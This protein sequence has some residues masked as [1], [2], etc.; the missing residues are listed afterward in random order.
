MIE[1]KGKKQTTC[2]HGDKGSKTEMIQ[3]PTV[4]TISDRQKSIGLR[5]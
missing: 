2:C 5:K 3:A 4:L 1:K